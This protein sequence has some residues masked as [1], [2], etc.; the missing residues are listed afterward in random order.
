VQFFLKTEPAVSRGRTAGVGSGRGQGELLLAPASQ[1]VGL[2]GVVALERDRGLLISDAHEVMVPLPGR[3]TLAVF[4]EVDPGI[5]LLTHSEPQ[6][7]ACL[8]GEFVASIATGPG[9]DVLDEPETPERVHRQAVDLGDA[10]ARAHPIGE[11]EDPSFF[12]RDHDGH[13]HTVG[14]FFRDVAELVLS[15]ST[16]IAYELHELSLRPWPR[17]RPADLQERR[18]MSFSIYFVN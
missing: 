2:L 10:D 18:I 6:A 1:P 17:Y 14:I 11:Q 9:A 13:D 5:V 3:E 8:V 16:Q 4:L 15:H 12:G 7:R